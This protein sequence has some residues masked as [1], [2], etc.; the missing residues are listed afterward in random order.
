MNTQEFEKLCLEIVENLKPTSPI[1]TGN[2]RNNAI[3]YEYIDK[4]T[5]KIYVDENIAPYMPYT[6]EPWTSPRWK[7]AK[8]PNEGWWQNKAFPSV[9]KTIEMSLGKKIVSKKEK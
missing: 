5:C 6:N 7:G 9:I 2:L 8:N 3:R 4:N 1:D